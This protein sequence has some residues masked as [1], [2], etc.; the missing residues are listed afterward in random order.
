MNEF[1]RSAASPSLTSPSIDAGSATPSGDEFAHWY[2]LVRMWSGS[3][4][5][6][7]EKVKDEAG[8]KAR[9][10]SDLCYLGN[11]IWAWGDDIVALR[12]ERDLLRAEIRVLA[13]Q[14]EGCAEALEARFPEPRYGQETAQALYS[15]ARFARRNLPDMETP[16]EDGS[17]SPVTSDGEGKSEGLMPTEPNTSPHPNPTVGATGAGE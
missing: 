2:G 16:P 15:W 10:Y 8:H 12:A 6:A 5:L 3:A 14:I 7:G 13:D 17:Q 11:V 1:G 4:F 9:L